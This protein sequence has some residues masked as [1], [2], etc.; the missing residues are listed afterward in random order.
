MLKKKATRMASVLLASSMLISTLPGFSYAVNAAEEVQIE[1][2]EHPRPSLETGRYT[3]AQQVSLT[4]TT[5]GATI[6]YTLD[7]T[8]PDESSM[9]YDGS[10]IHIVETTNLSTIAFKN[11][12]ASRGATYTYFIK[13]EEKPLLQFVVMSD[14]H[15]YNLEHAS[16]RYESYFDT[17]ESL[18][19]K[20]D[21]ILSI[22]DM[23]NDNWDG[24]QRDHLMVREVFEK[25]LERKSWTDTKI[26]L[27]TGNHDNEIR[28]IKEFYPEDWFTDNPDG[29]YEKELGGYYF[30]YLNS[31]NYQNNTKQRNWLKRR[32]AEIMKNEENKNKP[33][34]I[35]I[36]RPIS[37]TV[38]DGQ[39]SSNANLYTDL[40][41]YPQAI[42]FSGH[43]HLNINDDRS[44]HQQDFTS[45]NLGSMSYLESDHG[46]MQ[47]TSNGLENRVLIPGSQAQFVEVYKDRVE[48]DRVAMNADP[49]DIDVNG[50]PVPPYLSKGVAAGES[51]VVELKGDTNEEIKRNFKYAGRNKS[52]PVFNSE[53]EVLTSEDIPTLHFEQAKDDQMTHHYEVKVADKRTAEVVKNV[54]VFADYFFSPVPKDMTIPLNGLAPSTSYI[55]KVTAVDSYGNRSET[56]QQSFRTGGSEGELT[57][58]DPETMWKELVVDMKFDENLADDAK[59]VSGQAKANG[60]VNFVPG[61]SKQAVQI[62]AGNADSIDLGN[63]EDVNIGTGDYTVSFWHTGNLVGDQ[64]IIANKNWSSGKNMG[65]YVGSAIGNDM[66]LNLSDGTNRSD[67]RAT[68]VGNE[69]HLYTVTVDRTNKS[70][71][72]YVDGVEKASGEIT[73]P[74]ENTLDTEY[75]IHIGTDGNKGNGGSNVTLDDLKIWKRALNATEV[76]ALSDSYKTVQFFTFEQLTELIAQADDFLAASDDVVGITYPEQML[77]SF[78]QLLEA[79]RAMTA[80]SDPAQI[81]AF[82]V[83]LTWALKAIKESI[84]Y[85]FIP[86]S[87]FEVLDVNSVAEVDNGYGHNI[88]DNDVSTI[89]HT[90]WEGTA[91]PFPHWVIIDMKNTYKL[92]GIE[93]TSRL[94]QSAMEFPREFEVYASDNLEDLKD[95]QYLSNPANK[96]TG[97]F[98]KTWTTKVYKDYLAFDNPVQGRYVKFVVTNTYNAQGTFTSMSEIDFT[99]E[100]VASENATLTDLQINGTTVNGFAPDKFSY[101]V[102]VPYSTT[103]TEVTYTAADPEA[104]VKVSGGENLVVG[105]NSVLVTVTTKDGKTNTYTVNVQR[106]AEPVEIAATLT[107]L[108]INGTTVSEFAPDK[109]AYTVQ[110]PYSTTVVDVTYTAANPEA[111]VT[112]SGGENLAVGNNEV[113]VTVTAATAEVDPEVDPEAATAANVEIQADTNDM[114]ELGRRAASNTYVINVVRAKDTTLPPVDPSINPP[115]QPPV[116]PPVTPEPKPVLPE[117]AIALPDK[118]LNDEA[119]SIQV[120]LEEGKELIIITRKQAEQFGERSLI[121][122]TDN[123]QWEISADVMDS[124]LRKVP[125]SADDM[126]L[127]VKMDLSAAVQE[128]AKQVLQQANAANDGQY[129]LGGMMLSLS[130]EAKDKNNKAYKLETVDKP[131]KISFVIPSGMNPNLVGIYQ[132]KT[133]GTIQY[134]GGKLN[135]KETELEV[136]VDEF[137]EY[138]LLSL[139]KTYADLASSHWAFSTVQEMAAKQIVK[140]TTKTSFSP[141]LKVT[142]AEFAALLARALELSS[143]G[144]PS[145]T[146]VDEDV[147]YAGEVV[148]AKQAGIIVGMKNRFEPERNITREEMASMTV[149]AYEYKK[150]LK[151]EDVSIDIKD[152][153]KI[154]TWALQHVQTAMNIGLLK[155][156]QNGL[157]VPAELSTRVEA[158]QAVYNLLKL[159]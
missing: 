6:Y 76:K 135:A 60:T 145:F 108:Q 141:N 7:G 62:P 3:S 142:R 20:P 13:T 89:W 75:N 9:K 146:D 56:L 147:W 119:S 59:D 33:V 11:G 101:T 10:P 12:V 116:Q 118:A 136:E 72:V 128:K 78:A 66:T 54:K 127:L 5:P 28:Y 115:V 148:A 107:D 112:V 157:F 61:K 30:F 68:S 53:I 69:W 159:L 154:S 88:L 111:T 151:Q 124:L 22:G 21:A 46:Y 126:T 4:T 67:I 58:I 91:D 26:Q 138:A 98:G 94:N 71:K 50:Q 100:V 40:K 109:L 31:E 85:T 36:H 131:M 158:A 70:A 143:S 139:E 120:R 1:F 39:Q 14:V 25:N 86:K 149:R 83:D 84:I 140:G 80:E 45:I 122:R 156:R 49:G 95:P 152:K 153:A 57:P 8:L 34:F 137:G 44:I 77:G 106:A 37:G 132:V 35:N 110:V 90:H 52:A 102:Q 65:W 133:D 27:T 43:S 29:Y 92:S 18:F 144:V 129:K 99:G 97:S 105:D 114:G 150:M 42:V 24:R 121:V 130:L 103:R 79:A 38:M 96:V 19:P 41:D 23:I 73:V 81:D 113:K 48:V 16:A 32:L 74:A 82:Y 155:G 2:I 134:T 123:A 125:V 15:I 17:I 64:T 51:W 117:N 55:V 93:R 63:R 47:V 104:T 87:G